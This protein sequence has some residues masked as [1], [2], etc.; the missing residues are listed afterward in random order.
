MEN[1]MTNKYL[2]KNILVTEYF[3]ADFYFIKDY[4]QRPLFDTKR[5]SHGVIEYRYNSNHELIKKTRKNFDGNRYIT[6]YEYNRLGKKIR[7]VYYH[8]PVSNFSSKNYKIPSIFDEIKQE[9][10]EKIRVIK[11]NFDLEQSFYK[12]YK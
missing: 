10:I 11:K 8:I 2:Y 9:K 12:F 4:E 7:E 6:H 1:I 3:N 5:D